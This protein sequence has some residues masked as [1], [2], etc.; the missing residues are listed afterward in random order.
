MDFITVK[1]TK[2][3]ELKA[4]IFGFYSEFIQTGVTVGGMRIYLK[5]EYKAIP[6][7]IYNRR[8][9]KAALGF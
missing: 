6:D 7:T 9:I 2:V 4:S 5:D 8:K 1:K 3:N